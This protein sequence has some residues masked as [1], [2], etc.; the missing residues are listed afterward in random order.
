VCVCVCVRA[1]R[2]LSTPVSLCGSDVSADDDSSCSNRQAMYGDMSVPRVSL[3]ESTDST[4]NE[5]ADEDP[6]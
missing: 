3:V 1:V 4:Y 5:L 6:Q 2:G